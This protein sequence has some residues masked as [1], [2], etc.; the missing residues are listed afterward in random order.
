MGSLKGIKLWPKKK[1][2]KLISSLVHPSVGLN[3]G[4]LD[5]YLSENKINVSVWGQGA[6]LSVEDFSEELL[7]GEAALV[8]QPDGQVM[9]VVDIVVLQ[10]FRAGD[11]DV[12]ILVEAEQ[13]HADGASPLNRLPAVKRRSDE[14]QLLA[15]RRL[16]ADMQIDANLVSL[17][18]TNIKIL[19]EQQQSTSYYGLP[20]LYRKRLLT[21]ELA[22]PSTSS[23]A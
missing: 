17:D 15:A 11:R 19:E 12:E 18:P 21:A 14:H 9:R 1:K 13:K 4:E 6:Y 22:L 20:T 16:I 10:L 2:S 23:S 5:E 7:K 3:Q 8:T